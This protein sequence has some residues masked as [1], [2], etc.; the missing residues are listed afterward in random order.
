MRGSPDDIVSMPKCGYFHDNRI[1][2]NR[3]K[4]N[5]PGKHRPC[6]LASVMVHTQNWVTCIFAAFTAQQNHDS[7]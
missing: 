4:S 1:K 6:V 3:M 2:A 7:K 5:F